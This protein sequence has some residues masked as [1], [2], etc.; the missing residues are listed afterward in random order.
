MMS[1]AEIHTDQDFHEVQQTGLACYTHT[2]CCII[3][4]IYSIKFIQG[5]CS[6][7]NNP[8]EKL[9]H[10]NSTSTIIFWSFSDFIFKITDQL[11]V[12]FKKVNNIVKLAQSLVQTFYTDN[13]NQNYNSLN[14][15]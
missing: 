2:I 5:E 1:D 14:F 4:T 9:Q 12:N 13:T 11:N 15:Y 10:F 7:Q 6:M 3:F 8:Q